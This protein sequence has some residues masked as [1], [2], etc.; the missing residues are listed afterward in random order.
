MTS[1]DEPGRTARLNMRLSPEALD[2]LREAAAAQQQD[3]SAF[4]LGAAMERARNTLI[5]ERVLRLTPHEVL[6]LERALESDG[7]VIT[8]LANLI[9]GVRSSSA[10][11]VDA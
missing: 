9:R 4:V 7:E 11:R 3:L 5:E 6:Q 8:P 2:M 10:A 1:I